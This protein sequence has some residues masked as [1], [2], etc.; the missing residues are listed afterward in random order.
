MKTTH[1]IILTLSLAGCDDATRDAVLGDTDAASL[2]DAV[3]PD[4]AAPRPD[5]GPPI[6]ARRLLTWVC[7]AAFAEQATPS[8]LE[9]APVAGDGGAVAI[10]P[11]A[12]ACQFHLVHHEAGAEARLTDRPGGYLLAA[13][14]ADGAARVVCASRIEHRAAPGPAAGAKTLRETLGVTLECARGEAGAFGPLQPVLPASPDWAPWIAS[15]ETLPAQPGRYRLTYE[16]DFSFQFLNLTDAGRPATDGTYT[17]DF[18]FA[19]DGTLRADDPERAAPGMTGGPTPPP[20]DPCPPG[21][22]DPSDPRCAPR[23]GDGTCD[24]GESCADCAEDCGACSMVMDD[25]DDP[26]YAELSGVWQ[27]TAGRAEFSRFTDDGVAAFDFRGLRPGPK[28]VWVHYPADARATD[29]AIY[30]VREPGD[31]L[32]AEVTLD[33]RTGG[34]DWRRAGVVHTRGDFVVEVAQGGSGR[35]YA[36]AVRVDV[37]LE[38][39]PDDGS[40]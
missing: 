20:P 11:T 34:G 35:L 18:G 36:D 1:A 9:L 31:D 8:A 4:D 24:P 14:V 17:V 6:V 2:S 16:R 10:D 29:R 15:I 25:G 13:G 5:A 28:T 30:R 7:D 26:G 33:Q 27:T 32:P 12:E 39:A 19:A 38:S 37:A 3:A 22:I 21:E 40:P 23:C